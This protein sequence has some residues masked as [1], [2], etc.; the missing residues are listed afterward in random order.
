[1]YRHLNKL[2]K[3]QLVE[4][5][6]HKQIRGAMLKV[7]S[8]AENGADIPAQELAAM[9]PDEHMKL[10]MKFIASLLGDYGKYL[11]QDQFDLRQDG[12][13]FRQPDLLLSDEEYMELVQG[14]R[15]Q[16]MKHVGNKPAPDRRRRTITTIIIPETKPHASISAES[17]PIKGDE[18]K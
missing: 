2:L 18:S 14:L 11:Q 8:L 7:Y 12:V 4:V 6:E 3:A 15:T 16:L 13:S 9:T 5:V 1:M 17:P 10:F